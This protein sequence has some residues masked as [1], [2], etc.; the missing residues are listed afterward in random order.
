[1]MTLTNLVPIPATFF[2][3]KVRLSE[4]MH[5]SP[6]K[7]LNYM[8][9]EFDVVGCTIISDH[10]VELETRIWANYLVGVVLSKRIP[11]ALIRK[12]SLL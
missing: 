1:M 7:P 11:I 8:P 2:A 6:S 12:Y 5:I 4:V 10:R 9:I 3:S